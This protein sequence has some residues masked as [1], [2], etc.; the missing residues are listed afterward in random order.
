MNGVFLCST[1][2]V[3]AIALSATMA[4]YVRSIYVIGMCFF[5]HE[6]LFIISNSLLRISI[7]VC[8]CHIYIRHIEKLFSRFLAI[9]FFCLTDIYAMQIS[10]RSTAR[11]QQVFRDESFLKET[12]TPK[13][14]N[15]LIITKLVTNLKYNKKMGI[16]E[17]HK[18]D[19]YSSLY[20]FFFILIYL[21]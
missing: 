9:G 1:E 20:I 2:Y 11:C 5:I 4:C 6:T 16:I 17:I 13:F 3:I 10:T 7:R 14:H 8:I 18:I 19:I 21:F 15:I 12:L